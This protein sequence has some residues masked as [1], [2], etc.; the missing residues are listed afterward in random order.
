MAQI[1]R[2]SCFVPGNASPWKT[3][4]QHS[5][6]LFRRPFSIILSFGFPIKAVGKSSLLLAPSFGGLLILA[7]FINN[8]V[9][10]IPS[11]S[12]FIAC[13]HKNLCAF[14][15]SISSRVNAEEVQQMGKFTLSTRCHKHLKNNRSELIIQ[16]RYFSVLDKVCCQTAGQ[17]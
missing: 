17:G 2:T 14:Q 3:H 1:K 8:S 4:S 7:P 5:L 15:H 10:R 11:L 13:A 6:P 16:C 12:V 9:T